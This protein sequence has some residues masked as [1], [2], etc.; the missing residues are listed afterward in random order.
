MASIGDERFRTNCVQFLLVGHRKSRDL[1]HLS[2]EARIHC[3]SVDR[4][5]GEPLIIR[6]SR[7]VE[8]GND[9]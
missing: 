3:D 5:S 2:L 1:V 4:C 8:K 7:D 6:A 9:M